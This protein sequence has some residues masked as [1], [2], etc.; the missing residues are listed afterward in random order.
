MLVRHTDSPS[1]PTSILL[2]TSFTLTSGLPLLSP[3]SKNFNSLS[4]SQIASVWAE[5]I[6]KLPPGRFKGSFATSGQRSKPVSRRSKTRTALFST[7][8]SWQTSGQR[9][10]QGQAIWQLL[11][12][13][14]GYQTRMLAETSREEETPAYES[15]HSIHLVSW[16]R[17]R[18]LF[19][20]QRSLPFEYYC[21][22]H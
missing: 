6:K 13:L 2:P 5:N 7:E 11:I 9:D 12:Q 3:A 17:A 22:F 10:W 15:A 8:D 21:S 18:L 14:R 19:C 1:A 20:R 16:F 4:C